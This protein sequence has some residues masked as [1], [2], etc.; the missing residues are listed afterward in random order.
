M[1]A[2]WDSILCDNLLQDTI[3]WISWCALLLFLVGRIDALYCA[4]KCLAHLRSWINWFETS[5][6]VS[7]SV[8]FWGIGELR[9]QLVLVE[10]GC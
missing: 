8:G 3:E 4:L 5:I 1:I 9:K 10:S 6:V 2:S 7:C